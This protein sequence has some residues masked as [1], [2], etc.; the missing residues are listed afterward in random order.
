MESGGNVTIK[1]SNLNGLIFI[2][3]ADLADE[4]PGL[5]VGNNCVTAPEDSDRAQRV[6]TAIEVLQLQANLLQ[7]ILNR[8]IE[9]LAQDVQGLNGIVDALEWGEP[10]QVKF[11]DF[12]LMTARSY[13][14][15]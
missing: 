9:A 2:C 12:E 13:R 1:K 10:A 14:L 5:R 11:F 7:I 4:L 8:S 3:L 15:G 6:K